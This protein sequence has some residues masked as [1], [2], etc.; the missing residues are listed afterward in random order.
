MATYYLTLTLG[1]TIE[2][3]QPPST[4]KRAIG[5]RISRSHHDAQVRNMQEKEPFDSSYIYH[6]ISVVIGVTYEQMEA[7]MNHVLSRGSV[8]Q[9]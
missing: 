2:L 4:P 6:F 3:P 8:E 7:R 5:S 9:I 1:I